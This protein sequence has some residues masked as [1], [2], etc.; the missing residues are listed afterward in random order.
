[1]TVAAVRGAG[2]EVE[3]AAGVDCL[4]LSPRRT[5]KPGATR[6][7]RSGWLSYCMN[8]VI[9]TGAPGAPAN[10]DYGLV[11][12]CAIIENSESVRPMNA[13]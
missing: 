6:I 10:C 4:H 13:G 1:M 8:T 9:F 7:R 12:M 11:T 5:T 2:V 3:A